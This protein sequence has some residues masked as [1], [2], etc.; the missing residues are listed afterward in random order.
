MGDLSRLIFESEIR[1]FQAAELTAM[2]DTPKKPARKSG[3]QEARNPNRGQSKG[4]QEMREAVLA[5][6]CPMPPLTVSP[7]SCCKSGRRSRVEKAD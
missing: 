5:P 7:T 3:G 1:H 2:T 6:P 4:D